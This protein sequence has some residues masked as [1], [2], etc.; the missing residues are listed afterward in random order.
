MKALTFLGFDYGTQKIGVAVGQNLTHTA[1]EL[2]VVTVRNA[3]PDWVH[4]ARL[5]ARWRPQAL[6]VGL[7]LADDGRDT[8]MSRQARLF[9]RALQRRYNLPVHWI[10]EHLSSDSARVALAESG[11]RRSRRAGDRDRVAARLILES[12]LHEHEHEW[13]RHP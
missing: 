9:G 10:N 11:V 6:V 1:Q 12:F 7:P 13:D 4:L 3:R 5:I 2:D 8:P